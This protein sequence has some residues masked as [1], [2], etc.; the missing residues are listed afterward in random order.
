M[1]LMNDSKLTIETQGVVRPLDNAIVE[2]QYEVTGKGQLEFFEDRFEFKDWIVP[3]QNIEIAVLLTRY[4]LLIPT[5]TL[6]IDAGPDRFAF[7]IRKD[8]ISKIPFELKQETHKNFFYNHFM[9][10]IVGIQVVSIII[11]VLVWVLKQ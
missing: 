8:H 4:M 1:T 7:G 2:N 9:V 11:S 3:F 10:F 6:I 5:Y